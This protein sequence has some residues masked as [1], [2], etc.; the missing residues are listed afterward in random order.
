MPTMNC[1]WLGEKRS[2][3]RSCFKISGSELIVEGEVSSGLSSVGSIVAIVLPRCLDE[4]E[5]DDCR[6][7]RQKGAGHLDAL[8]GNVTRVIY[9]YVFIGTLREIGTRMRDLHFSLA[10]SLPT[11]V[12][13]TYV[14]DQISP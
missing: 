5:E 1:F 13:L 10:L 11:N 3:K 12:L 9:M 6:G 2:Y 7:R 14:L 4:H 8:R